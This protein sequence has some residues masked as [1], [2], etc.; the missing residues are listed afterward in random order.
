M[1]Y[2]INVSL[3][4][5]HY[6]ATAERS[7]TTEWEFKEMLKVFKQKFPESEGY[8]ISASVNYK[9]GK[10]LDVNE[11]LNGSKIVDIEEILNGGK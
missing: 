6:F 1:Y 2:E 8:R 9:T 11:I 10:I 4:G 5:R 3:N 7:L